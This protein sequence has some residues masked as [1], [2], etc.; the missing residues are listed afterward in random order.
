MVKIYD[1]TLRDGAQ[2][3]GVSFSLEDKLKIA[4]KLDALGMHYIEGG[5]PGSNPKDI[6]F[7]QKV[8]SLRLKNS[9]IASF[10]STRKPHKKAGED[11]NL[12]TLVRAGT[13]V[14]TV[15][16]KS[17]LLHVKEVLKT[18]PEENMEM[19]RD[20][21]AFLKEKTKEVFYDAEHFF[22]GFRD[23]PGYALKTLKAAE[24]A[25]ADVIVLCDTNGGTM[26]DE[27][28]AAFRE[29]GKMVKTPLGAHMHNDSDT[30][31]ANTIVA[32]KEGAVQVQGTINGYG[33]RSGNANLC[34]V[35]PNLKLKLGIDCVSDRSL[36]MLTEV[37]H[38]VA[39]I[40]NLVP[41]VNQPYVGLSAFVHKAG[42]HAD[43]V[44]KQSRSYEHI[45]PEKVGNKRRILVSE[46]SGKS[47]IVFKAE[48]FGLDLKKD[49][50]KIGSIL[51]KLKDLEHEGYQ[52]EGAEASFE[53]M[54][55]KII[56][57]HKKAFNLKGFKVVVEKHDGKMV[58]EATI[59]LTVKGKEEH[60]AA[61][62]DGPVNALDNALR[63][64]LEQFYPV[65]KEMHLTDYK[66]RII[67]PETATGA[68]TRVLIE[69]SDDED[70]W[71][72]VGVSENIIEASW[73]ALVDSIEYKLMKEEKSSH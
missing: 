7:F 11:T 67:N 71:G 33:E 15:F 13:D 48:E 62:G 58:S 43:A 73:Q 24:E 44:Q 31:V 60:T 57:Q 35:I 36:A 55:R 42:V 41:Q 9:K 54:V 14:I 22:D 26:P 30:A 40:A 47:S 37:S 69:S 4:K 28:R 72:T 20:T 51:K 27:V 45:E 59:R 17:W 70:T 49:D 21:I 10:G 18:T 64:A 16:G 61:L 5:W 53:L 8:R 6:G 23:D 56:G 39:E 3:E 32:V 12:Q 25:G 29:A 50:K 68:K 1:T 52:F 66:V 2:G 63:K 34:S 19:I 65:L 46:L 38:F